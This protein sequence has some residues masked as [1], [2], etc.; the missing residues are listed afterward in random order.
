[1]KVPAEAWR[2][3]VKVP[4][5][6]VP[7]ACISRRPPFAGVPVP[8]VVGREIPAFADATLRVGVVRKEEKPASALKLKLE[9]VPVPLPLSKVQLATAACELK[10]API[11]IRIITAVLSNLYIRATSASAALFKAS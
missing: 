8:P 1:M 7:F 2:E 4:A 3:K 11:E 5:R 6:A 9:L 10:H